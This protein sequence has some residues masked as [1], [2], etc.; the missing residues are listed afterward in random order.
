MLV[1]SRKI[2]QEIVI[3]GNIRIR[4]LKVKG[5]TIRLG[6]DAP[7]EVQISRGELKKKDS[8]LGA[9]LPQET[10]TDANFSIVFDGDQLVDS[11]SPE[12][13]SLDQAKPVNRLKQRT[14]IRQSKPSMEDCSIEFRGKLPET[15][16]RN[17][18]QEIV[19]RMA[20]NE[21]TQ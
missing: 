1:L 2:D 9:N 5:N 20:S 17:R 21:A 3:D 11:E 15:F 14:N 4:V 8:R 16:H 10:D 12:I 18:L 19:S 6:I 7:N 13:L